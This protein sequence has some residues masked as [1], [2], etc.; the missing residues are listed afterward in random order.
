MSKKL[1]KHKCIWDW[2]FG[3][4]KDWMYLYCSK[5]NHYH[6][7]KTTGK[8]EEENLDDVSPEVRLFFKQEFAKRPPCKVIVFD[9]ETNGFK[10]K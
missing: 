3:V 6:R 1:K 5:G 7:I 9:K 4:H 8:R 2:T 10:A